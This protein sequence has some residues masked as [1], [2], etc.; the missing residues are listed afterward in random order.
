MKYVLVV[1]D[2]MADESQEEL[3]GRTPLEVSSTQ[4]MDFYAERGMLGLAR[5]IPQGMAPGSDVANM[6]LQGYS[7]QTYYARRAPLEAASM[8][9]EFGPEDVAFPCNLVLIFHRN[10]LTDIT[11]PGSSSR[12][13]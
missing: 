11:D 2:G 7:P 4:N 9:L 10:S 5:T 6:S 12:L 1:G 8:G 13:F 3:G